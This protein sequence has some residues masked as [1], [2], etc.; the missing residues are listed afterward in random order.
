MRVDDGT[1]HSDV[2]VSIGR[3]A[4]RG[5]LVHP[6][7]HQDVGLALVRVMEKEPVLVRYVHQVTLGRLELDL[8]RANRILLPVLDPLGERRLE[9]SLRLGQLVHI[10]DLNATV[11][12]FLKRVVDHTIFCIKINLNHNLTAV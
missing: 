9:L 4:A 2:V 1:A 5:L 12:V 10:N 6:E 8:N 11:S 7:Y 3:H